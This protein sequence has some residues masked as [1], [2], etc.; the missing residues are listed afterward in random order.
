M[1]V[2]HV[3]GYSMDSHLYNCNA[4]MKGM[5]MRRERT[6]GISAVGEVLLM[7]DGS[8]RESMLDSRGGGFRRQPSHPFAVGADNLSERRAKNRKSDAI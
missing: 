4:E 8:R 1:F 7:N 6:F 2:F 3:L 5:V